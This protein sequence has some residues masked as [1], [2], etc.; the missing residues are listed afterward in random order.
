M[1]QAVQELFPGTQVTIGPVIEDGFFYDFSRK[2]AFKPSGF[3]TRFIDFAEE[4]ECEVSV[5][6]DS[7]GGEVERDTGRKLLSGIEA[8]VGWSSS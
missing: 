4:E 3:M 5:A 8:A 1:A 6:L 7:E 2:E